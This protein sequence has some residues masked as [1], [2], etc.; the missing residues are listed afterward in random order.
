MTTRWTTP[1]RMPSHV[2]MITGR[3]VTTKR[4]LD[5]MV[6]ADL[7]TAAPLD[8]DSDFD[9][10]DS[11]RK[12]PKATRPSMQ[13]ATPRL[14][15]CGEKQLDR[16]VMAARDNG[17]HVSVVVVSLSLRLSNDAGSDVVIK[18]ESNDSSAYDLHPP[19]EKDQ[20]DLG[21]SEFLGFFF[22]GTCQPGVGDVIAEQLLNDHNVHVI[23][24]DPSKTG[25]N[26]A[27]LAACVAALKIGFQD[28]ELG[29]T[30]YKQV[31]K[32]QA[33]VWKMVLTNAKKCR[34]DLLLRAKVREL[35]HELP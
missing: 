28:R 29:R 4:E 35:Y 30:L 22:S 25:G 12:R 7:A 2:S 26:F 24:V 20:V 27:R 19:H 18:A 17:S 3:S 14:Q 33:L 21:H 32:P 8:A 1:T 15:A 31:T 34:S 13:K 23:V 9:D 10:V 5:S 11:A 16:C 6:N